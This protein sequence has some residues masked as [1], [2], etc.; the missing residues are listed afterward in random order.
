LISRDT[1]SKEDPMA[2]FLELDIANSGTRKS[3]TGIRSVQEAGTAPSRGGRTNIYAADCS[4]CGNK[5]AKGMGSLERKSGVWVTTHLEK[6]A[7]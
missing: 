7:V 2:Y 1:D 5:V 3:D 4:A 6:C